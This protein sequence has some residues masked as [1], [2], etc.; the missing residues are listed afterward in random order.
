MNRWAAGSFAT[1][2][3]AHDW[4]AVRQVT[5]QKSSQKESWTLEE[6]RAKAFHQLPNRSWYVSLWERSE[7]SG[8]EREKP[9]TRKPDRTRLMWVSIKPL[10]AE[11]FPKDIFN[12]PAFLEQAKKEGA[13][14]RAD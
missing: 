4:F 5:W 12:G 1:D 11:D 13:R 9:T 7:T 3:P 2:D 14:V 8:L 6:V 10:R